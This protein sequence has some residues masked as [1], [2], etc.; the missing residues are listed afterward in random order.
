MNAVLHLARKDLA[1]LFRDKFAL[2][3]IFAFPLMYSLF[4]GSLFGGGGSGNGSPL[5]IAIVDEAQ[6]DASR[7]L[8][9]D[10]VAHASVAGKR[11]DGAPF[12]VPLDEARSLVQKG[13]RAAYVRIP[14]GYDPSP[15]A[16][17]GG[18]DPAADDAPIEIGIDPRRAAEAGFLQGVL[19]ETVFGGLGER[20]TDRDAMRREVGRSIE[21]VRGGDMPALQKRVLE[22]FLSSLDRFFADAD[23]DGAAAAGVG[24]GGGGMLDAVRVVDVARDQQNRPRSSFEITFP[25]ALIWGLMSVAMGFAISIVRER[26]QGTMLRLR[27]APIGRAHLLA[28][29]A[30]GCMI[31]CLIVMVSVLA[32]GCLALGVGVQSV[33]LLAVAM[34]CTAACFT[35]LMM[36]ASVLGKSEN[37]VAGATWGVMMPFAM[38]GGGMVPLIAMPEWLLRLSD[39]SPFKWGILALEGAIWRGFAW[40]DLVWPCVVLLAI[41]AVFF[42]VGVAVFRRTDG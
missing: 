23:F 9:A 10:L 6:T 27:T 32:F 33:T 22:T 18:G 8:V 40:G 30:L 17:F 26:T 19:M 36:T 25:S 14:A 3:W 16:L 1:I 28:G 12:V 31:A 2:F 20:F 37:A 39:L 41:G 5:A 24:P 42:A 29:K 11:D 38:I 15:F 34:V 21:Q 7:G 13:S 4:F 35:G